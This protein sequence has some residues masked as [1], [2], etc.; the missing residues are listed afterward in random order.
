MLLPGLLEQHGL[1]APGAVIECQ[2]HARTAFLHLIDESGHGDRPA[3]AEAPA[4]EPGDRPVTHQVAD[5]VGHETRQ[6]RLAARERV[7]GEIQA[8]CLA[9]PRQAH[10]LAPLRQQRAGQ[11]RRARA[12]L[13]REP[14]Q[15]VLPRR[16]GAA[17]L[18]AEVHGGTQAVHERRAVGA[19][20]VE[21]PGAQQRLQRAPVDLL[22]VEPPA[23]VLETR[24][25]PARAALR[26][27]RLG[28]SLT[29][30]A[31]RA[32]PITD[33]A[34]AAGGELVARGVDIR[35]QHREPQIRAFLD[36]GHDLVGV[37]HLGRQHR[38]HE[39]RRIVRL[40]VRGLVGEQR[41]GG[42]MRLVETIAGELLHQVENV[43]RDLLTHPARHRAADE[44]GA[45]LRHLCGAL[46]AHRA[47]QQVGAAE[48]IARQHL[49]DLHHLLLVEDHPVG[50]LEDRLEARMQVIDRAIAPA[51]L[52]VDEIIHHA[53]LQRAGPEQRD[54]RHDVLEAIRLQPADEILHAARLELEDGGGAAGL[55]QRVGGR[56]IH[57][58]R[59]HREGR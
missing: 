35:R 4:L 1:D 24:V 42:R 40:Q 36:E 14:E 8:E 56:V 13:A 5:A 54:Q 27:Q 50:G 44:H 15:I 26:D 28:R 49:R 34:L 9:L 12:L 39:G 48:R 47:P 46:L 21:A 33:A 38:R 25:H 53:G 11:L 22:Q 18:I 41:V 17:V 51:V 32:Q 23:K 30:A 19:Q 10:R 29:H 52:T 16:V 37:T 55:E 3:R 6:T 20:A 57:G 58:Q 2:D 43:R 45:L 59:A 7:A 31:H